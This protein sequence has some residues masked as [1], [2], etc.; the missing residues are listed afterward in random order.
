MSDRARLRSPG[1]L[2][3]RGQHRGERLLPDDHREGRDTNDQGN[4]V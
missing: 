4:S 1:V 2:E 3:H